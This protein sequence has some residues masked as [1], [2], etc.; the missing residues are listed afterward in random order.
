MKSIIRTIIVLVV[1]G[2]AMACSALSQGGAVGT[3]VDSGTET[4]EAVGVELSETP[5][6]P[7]SLPGASFSAEPTFF[8]VQPGTAQR[9]SKVL[10]I[11]NTEIKPEDVAAITQDIQVMSHIFNKIF[12]GPRLI[13]EVFVD[14]GDFFGRGSR[15][16]Q[17]IY[18]QG[19]GTLFLLEVDFPFSP[20]AKS[21]TKEKP[22]EDTDSVWQQAKQEMFSP[23][24]IHRTQSSEGKYDAE[25]VEE[26][27]TRLIKALK[28]TAN[29]R[30]I[31]PEEWIILTVIGEGG[32]YSGGV[33]SGVGG[34]SGY[35][36]SYGSAVNVRRSYSSTTRGRYTT[37]KIVPGGISATSSTVLTIRAKKSDVDAFAKDDLDYD[38]FREKV[39]IL[40]YPSFGQQVGRVSL[41]LPHQRVESTSVTEVEHR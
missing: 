20:P 14:F 24:T 26:L 23:K 9:S 12:K 38:K 11:P 18:L 22:E 33:G 17:A 5:P 30:N 7:P 16:T 36:G 19:Y 37:T 10:L 21:A 29:I 1:F 35:G 39:Q 34:Y 41:T 3:N 31:K 13:G 4:L 40:T 6:P 27:K 2:F 25:K 15:T 28:H 8:T 32:G